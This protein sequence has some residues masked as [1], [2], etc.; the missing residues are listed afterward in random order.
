L[1]IG[2]DGGIAGLFFLPMAQKTGVVLALYQV[3]RENEKTLLKLIPKKRRYFLKAGYVTKRP[4]ILL[5]SRENSEI[6][7]E[8]FEWKSDAAVAKAHQD[9]K[10]RA[11]WDEMD[12]L[13][14]KIGKG[15]NE[16]PEFATPFPHFELVDVY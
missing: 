6:F 15:L 10:V 7:I 2:L 9:P 1:S 8:I 12:K 11:I 14:K 3:A 16:V 4:P 13:C 5:R